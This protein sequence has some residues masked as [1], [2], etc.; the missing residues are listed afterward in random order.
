MAFYLLGTT[1]DEYLAP[2]LEC[3]SI[4]LGTSEQL[5]ISFKSTFY[6]FLYPLSNFLIFL[7][8]NLFSFCKRST[9]CHWST[10]SIRISSR[11]R[12]TGSWSNY[13][14]RSL[15]SRMRVSHSNYSIDHMIDCRSPS[16][17]QRPHLLHLGPI[18]PCSFFLYSR[19]FLVFLHWLFSLVCNLY[20]FGCDR[21]RQ[22]KKRKEEKRK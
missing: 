9:R 20:R 15:C 5:A 22:G 7:R 8:R 17:P 4:K 16:L 3:I 13:R 6:P 19:N 21:R 14:G 1:A 2:S 11:R 12:R 10:S 18:D